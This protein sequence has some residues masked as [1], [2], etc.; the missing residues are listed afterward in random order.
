[1]CSSFFLI[2]IFLLYLSRHGNSFAN[3]PGQV[4][5]DA[6][7]PASQ[8]LFPSSPCRTDLLQLTTIPMILHGFHSTQLALIIFFPT[9]LESDRPERILISKGCLHSVLMRSRNVNVQCHTA[10]WI[11]VRQFITGFYSSFFLKLL[12]KSCFL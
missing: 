1:M 4:S 6:T 10:K 9:S 2:Y 3:R 11:K 12:K 8:M 5:S 7:I